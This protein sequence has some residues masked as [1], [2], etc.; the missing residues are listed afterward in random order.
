MQVHLSP[1]AKGEADRLVAGRFASGDTGKGRGEGSGA[2]L[3][4]LGREDGIIGAWRSPGMRPSTQECL[5]RQCPLRP[6]VRNG[7]TT[8]GRGPGCPSTQEWQGK[9]VANGDPGA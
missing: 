9:L 4:V 2:S 5:M 8:V 7:K 1:T 3:C 6:W